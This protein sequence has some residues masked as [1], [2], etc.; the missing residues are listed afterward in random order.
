[1]RSSISSAGKRAQAIV[2]TFFSSR[3][4]LR[5]HEFDQDAESGFVGQ[6]EERID[7]IRGWLCAP[8]F[9]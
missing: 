8:R 1:M 2:A 7:D 9:L 4:F 6:R 3:I 5:L